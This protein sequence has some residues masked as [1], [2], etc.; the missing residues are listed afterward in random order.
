MNRGDW[1]R[2]LVPL[3]ADAEGVGGDHLGLPVGTLA[4]VHTT[5]D[6]NG[7]F[8]EIAVG[9]RLYDCAPC[10]VEAA[11]V[12]PKAAPQSRAAALSGAATTVLFPADAGEASAAPSLNAELKSCGACAVNGA[13]LRCT[14]CQ[15][16]WYCSKACQKAHWPAHRKCCYAPLATAPMPGA[17]AA[18]PPQQ[19]VEATPA[20]HETKA[21]PVAALAR[22]CLPRAPAMLPV[23]HACPEASW[24]AAVRLWYGAMDSA[25]SEAMKAALAAFT[26]ALPLPPALGLSTRDPPADVGAR[27]SAAQ[28]SSAALRLRSD[29]LVFVGVSLLDGGHAA[30]GLAFLLAAHATDVRSWAAAFELA[31]ALEEVGRCGEARTVAEATIAASRAAKK[32]RVAIGDAVHEGDDFKDDEFNA[33]MGWADPWQRP[34]SC[35]RPARG[36]A[37]WGGWDKRGGGRDSH[38]AGGA[39]EGNA[40]RAEEALAWVGQLEAAAPLI[41]RELTAILP[42]AARAQAT[43]VEAAR[44]AMGDT[45]SATAA[46]GTGAVGGVPAVG[47]LPAVGGDGAGGGTGQGSDAVRGS[48]E[49]ASGAWWHR[50]GGGGH[51]GGAGKHDGSVVAAGAWKEVVLIGSGG[52]SCRRLHR[53]TPLPGGWLRSLCC[54]G[55]GGGI[56]WLLQK[57]CRPCIIVVL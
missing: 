19:K 45:V 48:G 25:N 12:Q 13:K 14:R 26:A 31:V 18:P 24:M 20:Q 1:V 54:C 46:E 38:R 11:T 22:V 33:P 4:Q 44:N 36:Q 56:L 37:W 21:V 8:Y 39:A 50:V 29:R 10:E 41:L 6:L 2:T 42:P 47:G 43:A 3:E 17:A 32:L 27:S 34:G 23:M 9:F 51:R 15:G 57:L 40:E 5:P 28:S 30:Q 55:G 35:F 7:G 49:A 16:T 52:H 53:V